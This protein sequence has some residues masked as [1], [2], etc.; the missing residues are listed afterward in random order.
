MDKALGKAVLWELGEPN[1]KLIG[2]D[3]VGWLWGSWG[4]GRLWRLLLMCP[5]AAK[6]TT[7]GVGA[8]GVEPE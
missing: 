7:G 1:G 6:G 8:G 3:R 5:S 2:R 4:R